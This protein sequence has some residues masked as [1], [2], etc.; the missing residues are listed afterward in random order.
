MAWQLF[1][2]VGVQNGLPGVVF[3]D[4]PSAMDALTALVCEGDNPEFIVPFYSESRVGTYGL[5]VPAAA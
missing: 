2:L 5:G 1:C 4:D 3:D